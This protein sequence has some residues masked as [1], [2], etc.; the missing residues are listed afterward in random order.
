MIRVLIENILIFLLPAM[1]YVAWVAFKRDTWPG[2][3]VVLN[4]APLVKLFAIGAGLMLTALIAFSSTS[5]GRPGEAYQPPI[6]K[7]GRVEPG[8]TTPQTK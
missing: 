6:F 1:S 2:L 7:D 5:G 3:G 8:H 4:E